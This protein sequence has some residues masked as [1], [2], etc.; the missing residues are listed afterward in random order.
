MFSCEAYLVLLF[1]TSQAK[2]GQAKEIPKIPQVST[3]IC[4]CNFYYHFSFLACDRI[5]TAAFVDSGAQAPLDWY[6]F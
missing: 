5:D 6:Y 1:S 2:P 3:T 4:L